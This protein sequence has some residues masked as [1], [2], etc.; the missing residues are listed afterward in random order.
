MDGFKIDAYSPSEISERVT[1]VGVK[2]AHLDTIETI[3]LGLLAGAF[4][5]FGAVFYILVTHDSNLPF[6]FTKLI[7]GLVFSLGLIVVVVAG[8]RVVYRK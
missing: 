7:G 6:G 3:I 8:C 1:N 2:K 4:I 5:A